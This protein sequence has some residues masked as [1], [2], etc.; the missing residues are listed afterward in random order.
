[1]AANPKSICIIGVTN[2]DIHSEDF[3]FVFGLANV[4]TQV[5]VF[6]FLRYY[7]EFNNE[8][9]KSEEDSENL[10]LYRACKVMTHEIG[11]MFGI[12]HC[13]HYECGMNG[14]NHIEES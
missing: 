5:G 11:H 10:I 6:S 8:E 4:M 9:V 7:P 2:E 14:S 13:I 12:R 3:S 1:M